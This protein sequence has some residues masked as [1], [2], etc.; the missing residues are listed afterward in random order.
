MRR[1]RCD[2]EPQIRH[3]NMSTDFLHKTKRW[4]QRHSF[5]V[6]RFPVRKYFAE[7]TIRCFV[8]GNIRERS[9]ASLCFKLV[10]TCFAFLPFSRLFRKFEKSFYAENSVEKRIFFLLTN[11]ERWRRNVYRRMSCVADLSMREQRSEAEN[12]L[13]I[14]ASPDA[15]FQSA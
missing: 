2:I 15:F 10:S 1:C 5:G 8:P 14:P 9:L 3:G 7:R 6:Y 12:V 13:L 11:A 4:R